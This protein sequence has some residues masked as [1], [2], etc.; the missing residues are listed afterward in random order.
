MLW[1][2]FITSLL[3]PYLCGSFPSGFLA[4][5]LRGVDLRKEGSGNVG[6]TNAFRVLGKT[7]GYAVF[8]ADALKGFLAVKV[9]LGIAMALAPGYEIPMG[10]VGA[11]GAVLG[12]NFPVWLGF[13][14]GK[15]I[16]TS[17]GVMLGLFP[18]MV[19][20]VGLVAWLLLFFTTRYVSMA[21][22]ASAIALPAASFVLALNG[23]CDWLLVGVAFA[24][25]LLAF[26]R[27]RPNIS[28]L[29]AGT[30]KRFERKKKDSPKATN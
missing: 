15:G 30:E 24:M 7:W 11:V 17:A 1:I 22:L 8:A 29:L 5:K 20:A 16:S 19:F 21:S 10:V 4:G 2:A 9:A 3:A 18:P 12:H 6:A 26:W 14:G 25:C 23:Q 27:H 28:R 13:Q